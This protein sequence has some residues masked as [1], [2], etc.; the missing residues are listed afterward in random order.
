L[1]Q[2][3]YGFTL[4][5][6][7]VERLSDLG[8]DMGDCGIQIVGCAP[9]EMEAAKLLVSQRKLHPV[10]WRTG[11]RRQLDMEQRE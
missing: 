7:I 11:F 6:G 3:L 10:G 2:A 5:L 8:G 1:G 4:P 9:L